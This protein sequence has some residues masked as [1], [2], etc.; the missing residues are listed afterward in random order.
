MK[1]VLIVV[2]TTPLDVANEVKKSLN[3]G[4]ECISISTGRPQDV[5]PWYAFLQ[6][7]IFDDQVPTPSSSAGQR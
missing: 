4:W 2:G 7:E 6:K 5:Y 3:N 1:D